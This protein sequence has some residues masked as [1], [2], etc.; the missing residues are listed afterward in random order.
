MPSV[1]VQT[2]SVKVTFSTGRGVVRL[3]A[4]P[5]PLATGLFRQ[6]EKILL[7]ICDVLLRFFGV[8]VQSFVWHVIVVAAE[9]CVTCWMMR[10]VGLACR[11]QYLHNGC[12]VANNSSRMFLEIIFMGSWVTL[13]E[14]CMWEQFVIA[15]NFF[16]KPLW[17]SWWCG[18]KV[19]TWLEACLQAVVWLPRPWNSSAS[20]HLALNSRVNSVCLSISDLKSLR[21]TVIV[22][23]VWW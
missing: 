3:L 18:L 9:L 22:L 19:L 8:A 5:P 15:E 17:C 10:S 13:V 1:S 7:A 23:I 4:P 2:V 14:C 12:E 16:Y 11:S 6:W 21:V 20:A